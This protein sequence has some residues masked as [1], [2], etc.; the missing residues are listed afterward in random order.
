MCCCTLKH[1]WMCQW[2]VT[3]N[4]LIDWEAP[5]WQTICQTTNVYSFPLWAR[6][7]MKMAAMWINSGYIWVYYHFSSSYYLLIL[8]WLCFNKVWSHIWFLLV[9]FTGCTC[10]S[11]KGQFTT[12]SEKYIS[13]LLPVVLFIYPDC[14]GVSSR[15]QSKIMELDVCFLVTPQTLL[16]AVLYRSYFTFSIIAWREARIYKRLAN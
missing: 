8:Y 10:N 3:I 15:L 7:W 6:H 11:L 5:K 1:G 13:F 4:L 16:W 9:T 12:K 2:I 14:F